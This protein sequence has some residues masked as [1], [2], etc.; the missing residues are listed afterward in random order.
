MRSSPY[1]ALRS[2][3]PRN[4]GSW[5]DRELVPAFFVFWLLSVARTLMALVNGETFGAETTLAALVTITAPALLLR[6]FMRWLHRRG[7]IG[8]ERASTSEP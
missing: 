5:F 1:R 2:S 6:S 7:S 8:K 4:L 3:E